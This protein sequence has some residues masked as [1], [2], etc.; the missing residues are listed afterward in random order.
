MLGQTEGDNEGA[1]NRSSQSSP[2][3][4]NISQSQF[5]AQFGFAATSDAQLQQLVQQVQTAQRNL[6][7]SIV[8]QPVE[9]DYPISPFQ[10]MYLKSDNRISLYQ[11]EIDEIPDR[12][13]LNQAFL[14]VM[15]R[16]GLM[17]SS[18]QGN[19]LN[20]YRWL[21]HQLP[22]SLALPYLDLSSLDTPSREKAVEAMMAAEYDTDFAE[23]NG[24]LFHAVLIRHQLNQCTLLFN[25]D[26]SIFD[27]MSGQVLRRQLLN[28]Y[29]AL[30]AG[31]TVSMPPVRSFN[32]YLTQINDGPQGISSQQMI[33]LFELEKFGESRLVVENHIVANRQPKIARLQ[34]KV[35]LADWH[36]SDDDEVAFEVTLSVLS[37]ALARYFSIEHVPLKLIYQGRKYHDLAFFDTLGLF[38]DVVPLLIDTSG[39]PSDVTTAMNQKIQMLNRYN[40]NFVNMVTN[41]S[42][43][44][45]WRD[46]IGLTM[47]KKLAK[48]DPMILLN[49]A[50]KAGRE[51]RK[52]IDFA[53]S[54]MLDSP[55]KLDYASFYAIAT[56]DDEHIVLDILCNFEPD[57]SRFEQVLDEGLK[58]VFSDTTSQEFS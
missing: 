20:Q 32:D 17:R 14:D 30:R 39:T 15:R 36:I 37:Y 56:S 1:A 33:E 41:M 10:K 44:F 50:G 22:A 49:Y 21:Q 9:T 6:S 53:T 7:R 47:P 25:L 40:I 28:R 31:S 48:K 8:S 23:E 45:K 11:I 58:T 2:S 51:Y 42:S 19:F 13:L 29:Q 12:E 5:D 46:V 43:L 34:Y 3:Q 54:Q 24:I 18:L 4:N 26:H 38:V 55:E 35:N 57:M 27:N 16:Q 52:I